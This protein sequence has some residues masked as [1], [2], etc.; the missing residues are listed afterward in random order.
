MAGKKTGD[1]GMSSPGKIGNCL[2]CFSLL[3]NF[4]HCCMMNSRLSEIVI[5]I[6]PPTLTGSNICF[7][8]LITDVFSIYHC[9]S[10]NFNAPHQKMFFHTFCL[11]LIGP[12]GICFFFSFEINIYNYVKS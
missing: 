3:N 11:A 12:D 1:A 2:D 8:M 9:A 4:P 7:S 10:T 6:I 5:F